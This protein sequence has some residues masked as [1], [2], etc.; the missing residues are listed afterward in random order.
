MNIIVTI[1]R[2]FVGVLFIISGLIKANDPVGFSYKLAEYFTV[3]NTEWATPI[4]LP[5]SMFICVFEVV[6]GVLTLTGTR[7]RFTAWSL[8][9]MI[10]FFTFLTFYSAYF[11][12][13]TDCGCFGDAIKLTPWQSFS[14]DLILLVFITPIFVYRN[15]IQS[16][17]EYKGDWIIIFIST[18]ATTWFTLHCYNHLPVKDFRPYAIGKNINEGMA[19]PEGAPQ[20]EFKITFTYKN[21]QT[22]VVEA[23]VTEELTKKDSVWFANFEYVDRKEEKIKEGYKPPIHD[24]A[25]RSL[26]GSTD[27]T[28]DVLKNEKPFFLLVMYD[29]SKTNQ[30]SLKEVNVLAQKI[31][32]NGAEF[33]G[34]TASSYKLVEEL[35]HE[36]N[37]M[38]EFY[39]VDETQLKTMIRANPGLM[40]IK[41]GTVI[42]M[43]HYNDLPNIET[44][45]NNY[46]K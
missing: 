14:K 22:G 4:A 7:A 33:I 37:L 28:E 44:I 18:L 16:V 27:V 19:I 20:D 12:K 34:L 17:F 23:L 24:F 30:Q 40:L 35:R 31:I 25:I 38:F 2:V 13:V 45:K 42:N 9:S 26:D 5:L 32:E 21:K 10:I 39:N 8:M 15:K 29:V 36:N 41:N 46:L 6:A 11:N 43:W 1:S 3:F